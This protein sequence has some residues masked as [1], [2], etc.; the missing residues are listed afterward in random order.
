MGRRILTEEEY[1]FYLDEV[2]SQKSEQCPECDS[3]RIGSFDD[4]YGHEKIIIFVCADC[5][6]EF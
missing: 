5:G 4:G 2:E 6:F 3:L 1:D